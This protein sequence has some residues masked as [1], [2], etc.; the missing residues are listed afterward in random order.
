MRPP[1]HL[2]PNSVERLASPFLDD[3]IVQRNSDREIDSIQQHETW[4]GNGEA[5]SEPTREDESAVAAW[6]TESEDADRTAQESDTESD[7]VRE[8]ES[9]DNLDEAFLEASREDEA[10]ELPVLEAEVL[11]RDEFDEAYEPVADRQ[12]TDAEGDEKALFERGPDDEVDDEKELEWEGDQCLL[13]NEAADDTLAH[14]QVETDP[15]YSSDAGDKAPEV[16]K[17]SDKLRILLEKKGT[18]SAAGRQELATALTRQLPTIT[19]YWQASRFVTAIAKKTSPSQTMS[20]Y[21]L[22][23]PGEAR[24]NTGIKDLNDKILGYFINAKYIR[25]RQKAIAEL[26]WQPGDTF[27]LVGMDYKTASILT[28]QATREE[29]AKRLSQL[30]G[31]LRTLLLDLLPEAKEDAKK[32]DDKERIKR[33]ETLQG[34]LKKENYV[35]DIFFGV[36]TIEPKGSITNAM[37][38]AFLL[39]TE[40]LKGAGLSR[41]IGKGLSLRTKVAKAYTKSFK[42]DAKALDPRG[43]AYQSSAYLAATTKGID[44]KQMVS[45]GKSDYINIYVDTVWTKAFL[46][47]RR[48][49]VGNSDVIRDVRKKALVEPRVRDG[50]I[51][52]RV[53]EQRELLE[54]WLVFLNLLDYVK[55]F[56]SDEFRNKLATYHDDALASFLELGSPSTPISW[57]RLE[58]ILTK[59]QRQTKR[60]AVLG[61][62]SEFQ[63]YSYAADYEDRII[64]CFDIRDL[65]VALMLCYEDATEEIESGKLAGVKLM[66]ETFKS[67]DPIN[68]Q[69]RFTYD[70]VLDAFQKSFAVVGTSKADDLD[71]DA[72]RAFGGDIR[73]KRFERFSDT[74]QLMLGGDEVFVAAHPFYEPEVSA[75]IKKL[76][77]IHDKGQ[78]LNMRATV[79]YSRA[80]KGDPQ[81]ELNQNAHYQAMKLADAAPATLK[82]FE[83]TRRRIE[84]LIEK[85]EGSSQKKKKDKAPQYRKEL[86]ELPLLR[87]YGRVNYKKAGK[88]AP[89]AFRKLVRLLR[90]GDARGAQDTGNFELVDFLNS[91]VVDAKKLEADA[92]KL[93]DVVRREVG[94]ENTHVDP[95][96]LYDHPKWVKWLID[97]IKPKLPD[98]KKGTP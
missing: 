83:R 7:D 66:E 2:V 35:F 82:K 79:S 31:K 25:A 80:E 23:F 59:D 54:L 45:S 6:E 65:G 15:D 62:A 50:N 5:P 60:I 33:I 81:R 74:V 46:K 93:E 98:P 97:K 51:K 29:F 26:F 34:K 9:E 12:L 41:L 58:R 94:A 20:L 78:S 38:I 85:L 67:A 76:A 14:A 28:L 86:D 56:L 10:W 89:A 16:W 73:T 88:L 49:F 96:P 36:A 21:V 70:Q 48:W 72:R 11:R 61:T 1:Y 3:E 30:D 71:I 64:F 77:Q 27:Q 57:T 90:A 13:E 53:K 84:R 32:Y 95:T 4:R 69:R 22:L 44:L 55:D 40:A 19:L 63:F 39:V 8:A 68:E 75:V 37:D 18:P 43:K 17:H 47:Y 42:P 52:F 87:V 92:A 91:K 24:D